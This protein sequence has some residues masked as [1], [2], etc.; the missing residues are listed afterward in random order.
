M[1]LCI[2]I[3][4]QSHIFASDTLPKGT[5]HHVS[6]LVIRHIHLWIVAFRYE[7][8]EETTSEKEVVLMLAE[9]RQFL[10]ESCLLRILLTQQQFRIYPTQL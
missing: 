4:Q 8:P 7:F 9:I 5:H 3:H 6:G 10:Q 1:R 2:H